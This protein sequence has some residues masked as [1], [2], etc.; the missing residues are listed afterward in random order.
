MHLQALLLCGIMAT[1]DILSFVGRLCCMSPNMTTH[2]YRFLHFS[3][4]SSLSWQVLSESLAETWGPRFNTRI[5][6]SR[7]QYYPQS[8]G[9]M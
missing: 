9:N 2:A 7:V 1:G 8:T 6:F 5:M 3:N 4:V